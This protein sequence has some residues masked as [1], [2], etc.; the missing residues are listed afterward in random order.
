MFRFY[1]CIFRLSECKHSTARGVL[2]KKLRVPYCYTIEASNGFYYSTECKQ[3][4]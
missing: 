1:S 2:M 4:C 3:D